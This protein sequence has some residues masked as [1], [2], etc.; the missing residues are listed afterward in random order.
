MRS[1]VD[2]MEKLGVLKKLIESTVTKPDNSVVIVGKTNKGQI[3]IHQCDLNEAIK[4]EYY[5]QKVVD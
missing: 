1:E 5:S 2:N 4:Y 3:C